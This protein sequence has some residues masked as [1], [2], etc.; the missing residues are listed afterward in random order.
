M[1]SLR[2]RTSCC[3][4]PRAQAKRCWPKLSPVPCRFRSPSRMRPR[5]PKPAMSAGR[6]EHPA[7]L[8]DKITHLHRHKVARRPRTPSITREDRRGRARGRAAGL[9]ISTPR[10]WAVRSWVWRTFAEGT[11]SL[12]FN[13]DMPPQGGRKFMIPQ[14]GRHQLVRSRSGA[15][16]T[17]PKNILFIEP[18]AIDGASM[19]ICG[20]GRCAGAG[21][22]EDLNAA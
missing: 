21:S 22:A 16:L 19:P 11:V 18:S 13:A 3:W 12:G 15:I 6:R 10:S 9:S 5:S 7:Q 8:I 2:N 14:S 20:V 17:E 1:S 4:G